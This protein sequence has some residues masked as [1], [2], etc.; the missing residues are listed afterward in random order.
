MISSAEVMVNRR[1][2][3]M[4]TFSDIQ[5]VLTHTKEF[6]ASIKEHIRELRAINEAGRKG[7]S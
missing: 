7:R 6:E 5:V 1:E 4:I 3:K 2:D